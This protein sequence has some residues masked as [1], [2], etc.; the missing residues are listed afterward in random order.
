MQH[1]LRRPLSRL[2]L[3]ATASIMPDLHLP[4]PILYALLIARF[5]TGEPRSW[6]V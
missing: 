3:R 4:D 5:R 2:P 6:R 1:D